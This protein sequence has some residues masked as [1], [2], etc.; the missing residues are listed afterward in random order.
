MVGGADWQTRA[1]GFEDLLPLTT[2]E[3]IDATSLA[4]LATWSGEERDALE[5]A[6]VSTGPLRDDA[7]SIVTA[8]DGTVIGSLRQFGAGRVVL[9]GTD[10]AHESYRAWEG[11]PR[12]WDRL[13]PS[14]AIV[15][16]FLGG[17][18]L[19]EETASAMS[20]GL[21]ALPSLEVPPG[22]AAAPRD[23]GVHP[24]HRPDQL[25]RPPAR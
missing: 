16:R 12:L 3:A 21:A 23:R 13:V 8:D 9:I 2:L 11:S 25:L 14:T 6:T 7:R 15:D 19:P 10:L 20:T 18:G 1:S 17:G 22:G 4:A 5:P 24:A